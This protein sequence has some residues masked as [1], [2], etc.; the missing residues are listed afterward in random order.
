MQHTL[1][2]EPL[3]KSI[4]NCAKESA[5]RLVKFAIIFSL[6]LFSPKGY[7]FIHI[8]SLVRSG[9]HGLLLFFCV[10]IFLVQTGKE[11]VELFF[12]L[13]LLFFIRY[14]NEGLI[15]L[16]ECFY[17]SY[18]QAQYCAHI[19]SSLL[20]FVLAFLLLRIVGIVLLRQPPKS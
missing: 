6:F 3:C 11:F 16:C 8:S 18:G 19:I 14:P 7:F 13:D 10:L 4:T 1:Y 20:G 9:L 15:N 2:P 5:G 17:S 12:L